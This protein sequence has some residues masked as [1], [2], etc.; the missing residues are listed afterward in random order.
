MV[1]RQLIVHAEIMVIVLGAK[2]TGCTSLET[3]NQ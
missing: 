2:K 1:P 3:K